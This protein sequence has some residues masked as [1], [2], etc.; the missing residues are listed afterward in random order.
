MPLASLGG[1]PTPVAMGQHDPCPRPP[2]PSA[3]ETP[4]ESSINVLLDFQ[5]KPDHSPPP[6]FTG[7]LTQRL[8]SL[9]VTLVYKAFPALL[10]VSRP[11]P[12]SPGL[13]RHAGLLSVS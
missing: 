9:F 5:R 11:F 12:G 2:P 4:Q 8:R 6:T 3:G 13:A 1:D 7:F 10:P